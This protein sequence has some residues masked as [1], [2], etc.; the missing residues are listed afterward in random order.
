MSLSALN[1]D[2]YGRLFHWL[3]A[4]DGLMMTCV[5][6]EFEKMMNGA[7]G[8][9]K[10]QFN[11]WFTERLRIRATTLKFKRLVVSPEI[12]L[13]GSK[14]DYKNGKMSLACGFQGVDLTLSL[15]KGGHI[16]KIIEEDQSED[17]RFRSSTES[18]IQHV[19][20]LGDGTKMTSKQSDWDDL[21]KF[22]KDFSVRKWEIIWIKTETKEVDL[23]AID[24]L[25]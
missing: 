15:L 18:S 25:T 2:V 11:Q 14:L 23:G 3:S 6:T 9:W 4:K 7:N 21:E 17:I 20:R 19:I 13:Y 16:C 22:E 10:A 1:H 24:A 8:F 5:C 12:S